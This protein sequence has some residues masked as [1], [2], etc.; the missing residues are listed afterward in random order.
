M[1]DGVRITELEVPGVAL[2]GDVVHLRCHYQN[3]GGSSLY[4]LKWYKDDQEFYRHQ[5]GLSQQQ[6]QQN[7]NHN[8]AAAAAPPPPPRCQHH[9]PYKV[10]GV[11]ID[12]S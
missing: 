6:Q 9:P 8:N 3:E 5:P 2:E 7:H 12:V 1:A 4:T 10:P 11:T